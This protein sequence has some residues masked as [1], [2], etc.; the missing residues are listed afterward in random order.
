MLTSAVRDDILA[1]V[2]EAGRAL[3][4]EP[5]VAFDGLIDSRITDEIR[6]QLVP[7]VREAL[8]NVARHSQATSASV[9]VTVDEREVHL[10]VDD[11]GVGVPANARSG[12]GLGNMT[13]R[14]VALGGRCE[15]R[16]R[17]SGGTTV[18]WRVP[19]G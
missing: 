1:L 6:E 19:I 7:T 4:F 16:P 5:H 9:A 13:Q 14:A 15:V 10:V 8:S 2:R 11:N 12:H 3:G 18:D 17:I